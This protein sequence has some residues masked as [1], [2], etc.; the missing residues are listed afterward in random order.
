MEKIESLFLGSEENKKDRN[1]ENKK[2]KFPTI[3]SVS[4]QDGTQT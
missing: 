3:F 2:P 4:K 1:R